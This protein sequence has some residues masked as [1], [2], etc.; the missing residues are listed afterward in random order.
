VFARLTEVMIPCVGGGIKVKPYLAQSHSETQGRR[1]SIG[2]S[3]VKN[4]KA[5]DFLCGLAS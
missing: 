5:S 3:E 1:Q 2:L 4:Y